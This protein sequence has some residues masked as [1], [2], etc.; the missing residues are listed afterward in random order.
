MASSWGAPSSWATNSSWAMRLSLECG[1]NSIWQNVLTILASEL[2]S[3]V[4]VCRYGTDQRRP[5]RPFL[6]RT[7]REPRMYS[8][9][10]VAAWNQGRRRQPTQGS[11]KKQGS[12]TATLYFNQGLSA[13]GWGAS[14]KPRETMGN[15]AKPGETKQGCACVDVIIT[16][17]ISDTYLPS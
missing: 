15:Q 14:G 13:D 9:P 8:P 6:V 2:M 16:G 5:P 11:P 1:N 7:R 10:T 3:Y 17:P 12:P 4:H